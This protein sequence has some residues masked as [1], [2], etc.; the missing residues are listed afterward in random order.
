[1]RVKVPPPTTTTVIRFANLPS[2]VFPGKNKV[3]YFLDRPC[4][5]LHYFPFSVF[6]FLLPH[7][8]LKFFGCMLHVEFVVQYV[9]VAKRGEGNGAIQWKGTLGPLY[10]CE[11][12]VRVGMLSV[13]LSMGRKHVVRKKA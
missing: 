2:L 8:Y 6:S 11:V 10:N 4:F 13:V 9:G 5:Y 3:S 12:G 1:M 7:L